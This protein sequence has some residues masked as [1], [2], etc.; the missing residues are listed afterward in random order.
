MSEVIK[1]FV[2]AACIE[3]LGRNIS[4]ETGKRRADQLFY[5]RVVIKLIK[6]GGRL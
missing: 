1:A 5:A 3:T 2:H 6:D 4:K